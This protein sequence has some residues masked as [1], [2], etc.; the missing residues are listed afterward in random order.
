M[1][2]ERRSNNR[3]ENNKRSEAVEKHFLGLPANY[4][5]NGRDS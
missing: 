2:N 5:P 1:K 4:I 3:I